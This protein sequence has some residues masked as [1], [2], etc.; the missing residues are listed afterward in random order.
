MKKVVRGF[1]LVE[2]MVTVAIMGILIAVSYPAY[3][4]SITKSRRARAQAVLEGISGGMERFFIVSGTYVGAAAGDVP[5]GA[6]YNLAD[7]DAT[8][9]YDFT[10]TGLSTTAYSLFATPVGG[11]SQDGD[12]AFTITSVGVRGWDENDSSGDGYETSW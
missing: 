12:G 3:Q 5:I 4:N 2:L 1:S 10:A 8:T 7:E 9:H 11:E 6:V